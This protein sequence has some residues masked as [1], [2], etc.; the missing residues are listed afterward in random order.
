MFGC[1]SRY[2]PD[3]IETRSALMITYVKI[4]REKELYIPI[5]T[6]DAK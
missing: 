6:V 5:V 3:R 4:D 2:S 1:G